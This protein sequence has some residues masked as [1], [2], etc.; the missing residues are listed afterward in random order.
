M[1]RRDDRKVHRVA[2]MVGKGPDAAFAKDDIVIA[3]GHDVFGGKQELVERRG[4]PAFQQN[5]FPRLADIFEQREVLH[6][7]SADLDAVAIFLDQR[8]HRVRPSL[9]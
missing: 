1:D 2:S 3:L 9:R 4:Q 8:R 5:R 7:P 6:I